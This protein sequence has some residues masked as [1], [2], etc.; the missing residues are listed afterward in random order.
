MPLPSR[1]AEVIT[2]YVSRKVTEVVLSI[3]ACGNLFSKPVAP[4]A[5]EQL[6]RRAS[7][8]AMLW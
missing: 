2:A 6:L 3:F 1:R 4:A 5:F 8:R 7:T